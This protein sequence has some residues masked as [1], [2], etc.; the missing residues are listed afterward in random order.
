MRWGKFEAKEGPAT[1]DPP[2]NHEVPKG[3]TAEK[4]AR[5][6][7]RDPPGRN[8]CTAIMPL[9]AQ[10]PSTDPTDSDQLR[11]NSL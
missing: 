2:G 10:Q 5:E 7:D 11:I 1:Y 9:S 6:S 4:E 3:R 8:I